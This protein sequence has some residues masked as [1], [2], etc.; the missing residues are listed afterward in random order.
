MSVKFPLNKHHKNT[1]G[2]PSNQTKQNKK[3]NKI[4][5]INKQQH[6]K[7]NEIL[8]NKTQKKNQPKRQKDQKSKLHMTLKQEFSKND[9]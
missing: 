1:M 2:N 4:K 7:E 8:E 3:Q 5:L 9:I 6:K